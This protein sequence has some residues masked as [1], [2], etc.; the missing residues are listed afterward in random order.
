MEFWSVRVMDPSQLLLNG[1]T[2]PLAK[3][4]PSE[5]SITAFN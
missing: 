4:A 5:M 2:F 1:K 3:L